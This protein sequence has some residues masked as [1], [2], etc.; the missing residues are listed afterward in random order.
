MLENEMSVHNWK[1]IWLTATCKRLLL[2]ILILSLQ[3]CKSN[4]C[5]LAGVKYVGLEDEMLLNNWKRF[6]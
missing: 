2:T 5:Y 3:D 1:K 4:P 6:G